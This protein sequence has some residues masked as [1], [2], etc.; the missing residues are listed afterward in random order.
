MAGLL[1]LCFEGSGQ[2]RSPS[3]APEATTHRPFRPENASAP[4]AASKWGLPL[5]VRRHT[6]ST[7]GLYDQPVCQ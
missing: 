5:L 4:A 6:F 7:E 1:V 3:E 2:A